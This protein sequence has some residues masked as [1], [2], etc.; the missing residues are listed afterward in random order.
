MRESLTPYIGPEKLNYLCLFA[1]ELLGVNHLRDL[2]GLLTGFASIWNTLPPDIAQA[3]LNI[4][5]SNLAPSTQRTMHIM[6]ENYERYYANNGGD[7]DHEQH[8][9]IDN[10]LNVRK[11]WTHL[12]PVDAA[13]AL[14]CLTSPLSLRHKDPMPTHDPGEKADV[15]LASGFGCSVLPLGFTPPLPPYYDRNRA[16]RPPGFIA[17]VDLIDVARAYDQID[18]DDGCQQLG[19]N[20]WYHRLY[21]TLDN[22]KANLLAASD[23][24][25]IPTNGID[26]VGIKHL[27]G[28]PGSGKTTLLYL[29]AGYLNKH[30][31]KACFIFPSIEMATGFIET[32]QRYSVDMGLL[33]GQGETSRTRHVM[34]FATSLA[35][36]NLGFATTRTVAPFFATNCALAGFST[37]E[38][39]E[40]P[41]HM[42]PCMQIRQSNSEN[43][44]RRFYQ[45]ALSGSCGLQYAERH[46]AET[47][48]WAG[49]ILSIDRKTSPLFSDAQMRHFELIGHSFDLLIIDECDGAQA[50]MDN[51]GT[52]ILRV[53]GNTDSL[54]QT[55][56]SDLHQPA[57]S[58]RNAFIRNMD[59]PNILEMTGRF[60]T[61]SDRLIKV[62]QYL[63]QYF[64]DTYER[65]LLTSL[66]L[67][68]DMFADPDDDSQERSDA[69]HAVERLWEAAA[70]RIAYR[71]RATI[72]D[73]AEL[74]KTLEQATVLLCSTRTQVDNFYDM[75]YQAIDQWDRDGSDNAIRSIA[76]VLRNTPNLQSPQNDEHFFAYCATLSAVSMVVLQYFGLEPHLLLL[77]NEGLVSD[78]VFEVRPSKEQMSILPESLAGR[79]SGVRYTLNDG[80][81]DVTQIGFAGTPRCLPSRLIS[82]GR[83]HGVGMAVLYTSATS[84]LE[85]SSNFHVH[86]G[87][88]Y[89]L[90]RP[91]A[92]EG[93]KNSRYRYMPLYDEHSGKPLRFSG[94]GLSER[95]EVLRKMVGELL[96]NRDLSSVQNAIDSNDVRDGI[97]R[98]AGFVVNSYHQA[99]L[100]Y[101]YITDNFPEWR[102][103]LRYLVRASAQQTLPDNALTAAEVE[104]LGHDQQWDILIFPMNAIGRGV[105]IVFHSGPRKNQAMIGSLFFLTRPHPS[106]DSLQ[107]IQGLVGRASESFD[108]KTFK[109]SSAA[110]NAWEQ[111]RS[112]TLIMIEYLLRIPLIASRLGRYAEAFVADQMIIILQTI[113]R[114][115]RGDCPAFVYFVDSAWAPNSAEGRPDSKKSSMLIMMQHILN[116]CLSHRNPS[117]RD[118]YEN[119][120]RSFAQPL[121]TIENL[122]TA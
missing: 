83:D 74:D 48:L 14:N 25:L 100:L 44:R 110:T 31:F 109:S 122:E 96:K 3:A 72:A 53:T 37:D 61:A 64:K 86:H 70:K 35:G 91:N 77:N 5:Q 11:R 49:H 51:Q 73:P 28:L 79:L 22:P 67:I 8:F 103:R 13:E 87:P 115:M 93:W 66:S 68:T 65:R 1:T 39:E 43:R 114:A 102:N 4:R 92:G 98:K 120:Y 112:E 97:A 88:H 99:E 69:K 117:K 84:M 50:A 7:H 106:S 36:E 107:L 57:A 108:C 63:P 54:W 9:E 62:I 111:A 80:N 113:G 21:D 81:V 45:C 89:V 104:Q 16:N 58:G 119:L 78:N 90:Q 26:L 10:D 116:D 76:H 6:R 101:Q 118:C 105:N 41:H 52:P 24:G 38:D 12:R 33:S 56:I 42:P 27:I 55:L 47:N 85:Q 46:L 95:D 2:P 30:G 18:R 94:A 82:L 20:R 19:E 32:M 121:N 75:L 17:W 60:G 34:N 71:G 29:L 15:Q 40:F 23:N 59:M